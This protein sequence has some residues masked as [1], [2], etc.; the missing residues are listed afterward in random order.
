MQPIKPADA[1]SPVPD[2]EYI[3]YPES[4]S[5]TE[6]ALWAFN[7]AAGELARMRKNYR[8]SVLTKDQCGQMC[9]LVT[10]MNSSLELIHGLS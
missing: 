2:I 1:V 7:R 8:D 9:S 10:T 6:L 5:N 4:K 3:E